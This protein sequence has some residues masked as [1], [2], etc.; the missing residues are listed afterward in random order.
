M[1]IHGLNKLTL[2][3]YPGLTA[4]TVF[5]GG[6]NFRCPFCHN[7]SLVLTPESQPVISEEEFFAFLDKRKG[8]LEGVCITGGEPTLQPDLSDFIKK[9]KAA[10]YKVKLDTNGTRPDVIKN[11]VESGLVD[12]VA[13]DIKNSLKKYGLSAGIENYDTANVEKS[14]EYL[15]GGL[16]DYEFRTT[17]V[18]GL[19]DRKSFEDLAETLS[20]AEK[21]FLQAF[22]DSG[23]LIDG[24]ST[25]VALEKMREFLPLLRKT[26]RKVEIRGID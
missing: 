5:T 8:L 2:L 11:L 14:I 23:D 25:G 7:R 4:C 20:G 13:M 18:G 26:I 24:T 3:D 6:C 21:Y 1:L 10:G 22:M 16:V 17:V 19:N 12:Y 15:K 9:I